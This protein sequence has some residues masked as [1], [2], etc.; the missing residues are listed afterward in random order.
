MIIASQKFLHVTIPKQKRDNDENKHCDKI[1]RAFAALIA[2][3]LDA[4]DYNNIEEVLAAFTNGPA[5]SKINILTPTT[6]KQTVKDSVW[7]ELWWETIQAE[8]NALQAN[9]I[10]EEIIP[11]KGVNI[12]TSKWVFKLKLH[13]N[14]SL[15]KLK[16]RLMTRGFSQ[17]FSVD[18]EGMFAST[19][20]FDTL[21]LFLTIVALKDLECHMIDDNNAFTE[22]ILKEDIYMASLSGVDISSDK[23]FRVLQSLYGLKQAAWDW[24]EKC[25][26]EIIKL[27]F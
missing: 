15:D 27:S 18:F 26:T 23:A 10:W 19:F 12:V 24:H 9:E 17:V 5:M 1:L 11:P 7:G 3:E 6:Y 8:L 20:R 14:D 25:I 4:D 16:A 21:C 2:E 13:S 22:L